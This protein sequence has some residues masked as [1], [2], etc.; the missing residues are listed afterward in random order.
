MEDER[1][2]RNVKEAAGVIFWFLSKTKKRVFWRKKMLRN[3]EEKK[4]L[5]VP[6]IVVRVQILYMKIENN[7][8]SSDEQIQNQISDKL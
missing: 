4:K 2:M 8:K 7:Q 1:R 5:N 6:I 3:F